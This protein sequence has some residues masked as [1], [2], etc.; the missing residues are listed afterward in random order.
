MIPNIEVLT[1]KITEPEYP[2]NTYKIVFAA[3]NNPHQVSRG[4]M[5][6]TMST[7]IEDFDRIS[8][9]IDDLEAVVQAVYLI[10]S[11]ER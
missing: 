9:Y 11:T 8:G 4:I 7:E 10:L 1:E 5:S 2:G 3:K 6:L